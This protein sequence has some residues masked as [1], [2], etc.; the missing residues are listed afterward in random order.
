MLKARREKREAKKAA[1]QAAERDPQGGPK[2]VSKNRLRRARARRD[3]IVAKIEAA[4]SRI[5]EINEIF[6][7]PAYYQRNDAEA[8]RALEAEQS[9]LKS[10][11]DE[12]TAQWEE[13]EEALQALQ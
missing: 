11:V 10:A 13:A 1:R 6:C 12:L 7:D 3:E 5:D 9:E 2:G 8:V 4:E